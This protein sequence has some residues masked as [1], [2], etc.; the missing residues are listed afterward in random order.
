MNGPIHEVPPRA[1]REARGIAFEQ[2]AEDDRWE[3][4]ALGTVRAGLSS[5]CDPT[6]HMLPTTSPS[7]A[8]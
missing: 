2:V 6:L 7:A 3:I 4:W 1:P 8:Q 5:S